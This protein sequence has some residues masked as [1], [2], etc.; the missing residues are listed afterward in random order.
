MVNSSIDLSRVDINEKNKINQ[1]IS[2]FLKNIRPLKYLLIVI[3][4]TS[5]GFNLFTKIKKTAA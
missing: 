5:Q 4:I 1:T 3:F 2:N